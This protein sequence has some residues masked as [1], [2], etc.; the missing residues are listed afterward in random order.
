MPLN[1]QRSAVELVL[2]LEEEEEKKEEEATRATGRC[3]GP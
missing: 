1:R 2:V 3:R